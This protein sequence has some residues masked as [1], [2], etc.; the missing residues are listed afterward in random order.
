MNEQIGIVE[1]DYLYTATSQIEN[2][3]LGLFT[4]IKIYQ[5]E[6]ISIFKGEILED[7]EAKI[8]ET[9]GENEYF[10]SLLNGK[11][12]DSKFVDCFAKYANDAEGKFGSKF[13]NNAKI[14]LD[15]DN[16]VCLIATKNI[17]K[18]GE[19]FASYGAAYWVEK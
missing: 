17:Q 5:G 12:M 14:S 9:R 15:D 10:I 16:N 13:K 2:A 18:N 7:A 3:G 1:E 19:V 11:M 8:R 6:I 4:A